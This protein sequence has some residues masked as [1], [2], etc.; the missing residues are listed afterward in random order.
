MQLS[1]QAS[2]EINV[3]ISLLERFMLRSRAADS[4]VYNTVS[5]SY[6]LRPMQKYIHVKA[7]FYELVIWWN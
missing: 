2:T 4:Q 5:S 3:D 6:A 1:R 7:T